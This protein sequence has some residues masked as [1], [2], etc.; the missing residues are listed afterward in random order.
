M[1]TIPATEEKIRPPTENRAV[2]RR[3]NACQGIRTIY[4]ASRFALA[5]TGRS[6]FTVIH[7]VG[8]SVAGEIFFIFLIGP[9]CPFFGTAAINVTLGASLMGFAVQD[10]Q[11]TPNPNA[12]KFIL[13]RPI[14]E[15]PTS[16][17]NAEAAVGHPLATKLFAIPGVTS[18][19]LLGDF[20]TV[21]KKPDAKWSDIKGKV[22][23][24]LAEE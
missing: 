7:F 3:V 4:G 14:V 19:L 9:S 6:D 2:Y 15:Q 18:L 11:P 20:I 16:F 13:D 10:I 21:N 1:Q 8:I 5:E 12:A 23:K 24:I 17:F 22:E